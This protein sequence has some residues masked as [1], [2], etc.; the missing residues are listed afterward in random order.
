MMFGK[1]W[2]PW[3]RLLPIMITALLLCMVFWKVDFGLLIATFRRI[4]VVWLVAAV[5]LYGALF[6]PAAWRWHLV[7]KRGGKA[8]NFGT[9]LRFSL[10][11][12]FFYT[13]LFGVLGGDSAKAVVYARW[14]RLP[15]E[16]ILATTPLDRFL[17]LIGSLVFA[18]LAF[19]VAATAGGFTQ[20]R[21]LSLNLPLRWLVVALIILAILLVMARQAGKLSG[22]RRFW[23]TLVNNALSLARSPATLSKGF[24]CGL[25]VQIA[26]SGVLALN[27]FAVS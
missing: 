21:Q 5:A 25:L 8:K 14:H 10:I 20:L 26:L 2:A 22:W 3:V 6:L 24:L 23:S 19:G 17:G 11:G 12:H 15:A 9:T 7:L 18:G 1:K 16:E 13:I 27:L 4:H